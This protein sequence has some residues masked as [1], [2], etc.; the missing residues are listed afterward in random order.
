[1]RGIDD[2][3]DALRPSDLVPRGFEVDEVGCD[4]AGLPIALRAVNNASA[5]P[6]C[7][8]MRASGWVL[9]SCSSAVVVVMG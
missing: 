8:S 1:M 3:R 2:R 5:C 4:A 7:G 6:E 9:P